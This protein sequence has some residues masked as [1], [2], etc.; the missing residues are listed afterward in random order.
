MPRLSPRRPPHRGRRD[1]RRG[2]VDP[3]HDD[4]ERRARDAADRAGRAAVDDPVGEHRLPARARD[5]DP[6]DRVGR[7]AL[8]PEAGV[9]ERRGRLRR[10]QRPVRP[11]VERRVAD[12]LPRAPGL[13]RR[14]D[15]ADR[16]DH[17][18]AGRGARAHGPR[19]E[20]RRRADAAGAGARPR[21]R[22][23][24]RPEPVVAL[25]LPREPPG[26]DRRARCS[27]AGCC[28][29]AARPG[30]PRRTGTRGR[31]GLARARARV[32]GG[33]RDRVRHLEYGAH[34]TFAAP[35]AWLP[36][37]L[38]RRRAVAAF[39]VHACARATRSSTSACSA[40]AA[41][42]PRRRPCSSPASRCSAR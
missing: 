26:R 2:H 18:R 33:R 24:D 37:V 1:H 6:A 36:L 32:A 25:D 11:G 38:G 5:G 14:H 28:P 35:S 30:A 29:P 8:R 40:R 13:R 39:V 9:D 22:R 27:R 41:S 4:R 19:D 20:R 21:H 31:A 7:R 34:R 15:H 10:D 12:R 42:R 16:D 17:P 23:R 3:R